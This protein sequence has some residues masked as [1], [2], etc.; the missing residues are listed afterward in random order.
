[1]KI[2]VVIPARMA[3]SR[4]PEK[5]LIQI[6]G[7]SLIQ[8][9]YEQCVQAVDARDV[10]VATDHEKIF[11]HCRNFGAQVLMTPVD[12]LTG[13]DRVAQLAMEL[14]ADYYVNVQGDE[15]LI[16]PQDIRSVLSARLFSD[17]TADYFTCPAL[18]SLATKVV[19]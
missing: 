7:K 14:K 9:T 15:P 17:R 2:I 8:R 12:C 3:S 13:T 4:L 5:P 10:V 6:A 19:F 1:M 16:N 18:Q 11:N